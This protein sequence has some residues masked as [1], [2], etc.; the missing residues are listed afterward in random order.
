MDKK[1]ANAGT[2][3][4]FQSQTKYFFDTAQQCFDHCVSDFSSKNMSAQE[5]ECTKGCFTKQMTIFGSLVQNIQK[6]SQSQ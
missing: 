6:N 3:I 2:F 1:Q 4:D 5:K